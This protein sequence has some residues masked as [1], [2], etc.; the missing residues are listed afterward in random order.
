MKQIKFNSKNNTATITE[1]M[2]GIEYQTLW[3]G[4]IMNDL[5][6]DFGTHEGVWQWFNHKGLTYIQQ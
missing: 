3:K 1:D 2:D 4:Y 5:P 6:H